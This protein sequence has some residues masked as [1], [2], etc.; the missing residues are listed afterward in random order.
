MSSKK[1]K[2]LEP[3]KLR[4]LELKNRVVMAPMTRARAGEVRIPNSVMAEYYAQRASAGLIV[5]EATTI[6]YM[7]AADLV[8]DGGFMNV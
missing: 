8:V 7:T 5:T 6:S 2:L 1:S 4:D 3:F